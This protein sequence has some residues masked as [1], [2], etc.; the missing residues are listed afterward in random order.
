MACGDPPLPHLPLPHLPLPTEAPIGPGYAIRTPGGETNRPQASHSHSRRPATP[1]SSGPPPGPT[2]A[3]IGFHD[4]PLAGAERM[5]SGADILADVGACQGCLLRPAARAIGRTPREAPQRRRL[6]HHKRTRSLGPERWR[7]PRRLRAGEA[8]RVLTGLPCIV[9]ARS[10]AR[11]ARGV[12]SNT[13]EH[14]RRAAWRPRDLVAA[15]A[16]REFRYPAAPS[17]RPEKA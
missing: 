1:S 10:L 12:V 7:A 5:A 11:R 16:P 8:P 3:A 13:A 2:D 14:G 4:L 15:Q 9:L 6:W 17:A